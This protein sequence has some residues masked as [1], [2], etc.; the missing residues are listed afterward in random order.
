MPG[1]VP[2]AAAPHMSLLSKAPILG[3]E[4]QR[5]MLK[6]AT[7]LIYAETAEGPLQAHFFPPPQFTEEGRYPVVVFFHGGFWDTAMPTQFVPHCHH[8]A[9]RGAI[10]VALE[11][12]VQSVHGSGPL[13]ALEDARRFLDWLAENADRFHLD[14][15]QLVFAG[16]SGGAY[17]AL[18][19]AMPKLPKRGEP[20]LT[21]PQPA[22]LMLYSALVDPGPLRARFP[23]ARTLR[24]HQP[25]RRL[26]RGLPP[27]LFCHGK[28]DRV[29]P[30]DAVQRF[31][32][33]AR[34]RRNKVTLIDF[35]KADHSF[36]NFNVSELHYELTL[37][38]S[39]RF[40]VDLGMLPVDPLDDL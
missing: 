15:S 33:G 26:R 19:L 24:A 21:G 29:T 31:A 7:S 16:A 11:T 39:D 37:K 17:L 13:E 25:L 1:V 8:F 40:L 10:A 32:K 18:E 12:R 34:W 14:L 4:R 22:A 3:Q 6:S 27:M 35:E 9:N 20:P 30:F 2:T 23:D 28:A 38:A 36:F 5:E